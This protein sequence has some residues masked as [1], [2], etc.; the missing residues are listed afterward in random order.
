MKSL[1]SSFINWWTWFLTF[2]SGFANVSSLVLFGTAVTHH[3]GNISRLTLSLAEGNTS[4]FLFLLGLII[5]FFLGSLVSG[6]LF[7]DQVLRPK[8]RYGI[9]LICLG[10][11]LFL[12]NL[13]RHTSLIIYAIS[14]LSG[15][16]NAMFLY[17]KSYLARTTHL[18]GYLTDTG[19]S[20]GRIL[21][22]YPGDWGKFSF[23]LSQIFFFILGGILGISICQYLPSQAVNCIALLYI[24]GGL[25]YFFFR[26]QLFFD[27][28]PKPES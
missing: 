15:T 25:I 1:L 14:F 27:Q 5:F 23:N 2:T 13:T 16:Q 4:G 21:S 3:S 24:I 20:L 28:K 22:G 12:V 26:R 9:L 8:K 17:V 11:F 7:H 19:F 18:T 6:I 10:I